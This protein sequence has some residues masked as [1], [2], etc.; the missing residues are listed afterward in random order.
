MSSLALLFRA[1]RVK[2]RKSWPM[3]MAVLAPICQAAF[4][5][6]LFWFSE[7]RFQ[8]FKPGFRFWLEINY[9]AWN[10][11]V[12][13][14]GVAL[15]CELSWDQERQA[16]AWNLLLV[17]PWSRRDHYLVKVLGHLALVVLAQVLLALVVLAGGCILQRQ[18]VLY[19]GTL[20]AALLLRF[21]GFSLAASVAVVA[22]QTW[23]SLRVSGLWGPLAVAL[24]GSWVAVQGLGRTAL[25]QFLPWGMAAHMAMVFERWRPLP[26]AVAVGSLV[27]AA[28]LI[29]LGALDF[30]FRR[31]PKA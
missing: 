6:L 11:I 31:F 25:V 18:P 2:L 9:V 29:V 17:Q 21:I 3:L 20:P 26:W 10:L 8:Q 24:L 30:Q 28:A 16:R 22:F 13:P 23:L 5:G 4:L 15:L 12:M 14:I 7:T 19:M 27:T 1:E